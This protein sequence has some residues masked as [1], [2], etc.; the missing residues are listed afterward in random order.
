MEIEPLL[1][2]RK[3]IDP[4]ERKVY[5]KNAAR[6]NLLV[7]TRMKNTGLALHRVVVPHNL[8]YLVVL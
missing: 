1:Q 4:M 6:G 5:F 2:P 8:V 7:V 3:I